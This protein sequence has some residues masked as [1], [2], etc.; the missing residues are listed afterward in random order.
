MQLTLQRTS[1]GFVPADDATLKAC[2]KVPI[3]TLV[4]RE[5]KKARNGKHHRLR[6]AWVPDIFNYI[7]H[8]GIFGNAELLRAHL[9]LQTEFVIVLANP[10]TGEVNRSPRSWS[11]LSMDEDEFSE[12]IKQMKPYLMSD[13]VEMCQMKGN[14]DE[15]TVMHFMTMVDV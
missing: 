2:A 15:A 11:Y 3:G 6:F 5:W 9:T 13:F 10:H 7:E 1:T 12:M 8:L 14:W 4:T